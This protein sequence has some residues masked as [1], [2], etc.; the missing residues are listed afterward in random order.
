MPAAPVGH[1]TETTFRRMAA[2]QRVETASLWPRF[3]HAIST[4]VADL[5]ERGLLD[6]VL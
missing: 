3:D 1:A 5:D 6:D 2:S 4:L